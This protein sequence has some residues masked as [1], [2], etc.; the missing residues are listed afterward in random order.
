MRMLFSCFSTRST[1]IVAMRDKSLQS[2][3]LSRLLQ[4]VG[5]LRGTALT[6]IKVK[7]IS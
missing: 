6:F 3:T 4:L 5:P 7:R 1:T 2:K